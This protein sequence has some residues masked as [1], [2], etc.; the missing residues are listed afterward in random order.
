MLSIMSQN[1][2]RN[3]ENPLEVNNRLSVPGP[4]RAINKVIIPW[5][6]PIS[7]TFTKLFESASDEKWRETIIKRHRATF[8]PILPVP[9][10]GKLS[11]ETELKL[12]IAAL[13]CEWLLARLANPDLK[14]LSLEEAESWFL[15]DTISEVPGLLSNN[16][17]WLPPHCLSDLKGFHINSDFFDL[18]PY[19]LEVFDLID[20]EGKILSRNSRRIRQKLQGVVYTPSDV[21]DYIIRET[22]EHSVSERNY[23]N[24]PICLDPACGTGLFLRSTLDYLVKHNKAMTYLSIL[25][26][27]YGMDI[28]HQAIQSSAFVI[29]A[30]YL[31][32]DPMTPIAPWRVW[33]L[34]RGNLSVI[35]TTLVMR[36]QNGSKD[37]EESILRSQFK[38]NLISTESSIHSIVLQASQSSKIQKT[39]GYL[40]AFSLNDVFPEVSNGF[41]VVVGNPPYSK[42]NND[43]YQAI[44][45]STYETAA[46]KGK[47]GLVYPLFAE[48]L[49]N[50]SNSNRCSGGMILPLS[51]SYSSFSQI[52]RLRKAIQNIPGNWRFVFFDRTPDSLFGDDVKTRNAIVLWE[53][54]EKTN[55]T[56]IST[57]TLLRWNSR[58]RS[59]LFDDIHNVNIRPLTIT[60]LIPKLGTQ[61]ELVTYRKLRDKNE[62]IASMIKEEKISLLTPDLQDPRLVIINSTGY[63]WIPIYREVPT[64]RNKDQKVDIP[65]SIHVYTCNNKDYADFVFACLNSR[66]TYWLWR[67]ESDCF[68]VTRNFVNNLPYQA[69]IFSYSGIEQMRKLSIDLW[70]E[71]KSYPVE[72]VNAGRTRTS[73]YPYGCASTLD[74]IDTLLARA[75]GLSDEF[76]PFVKQ[77]V[78]DNIF[79]GR[80]TETQTNPALRRFKTLN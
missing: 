61:L 24:I 39:A 18:F 17:Q 57:S 11:I 2:T 16:T 51:I 55:E 38:E 28:S 5:I 74:K 72:S 47:T 75:L 42:L 19:I 12:A 7:T 21:S 20:G 59:L 79:A 31:N 53:R 56:S 45:Y 77:F 25:K 49:W 8:D 35:D 9:R 73:Y 58:K 52:K 32:A 37:P 23:E 71:M 50:F 70:R 80:E 27:L 1:N 13:L 65:S 69:S 29:L 44:R 34:I 66:I 30:S 54:N 36:I 63:N 46:T 6:E 67:V 22:L 64:S 14:N 41:D 60:K 15:G 43:D 3:T 10:F 48:M 4:G 33:Q 78:T 26:S 68:H 40:K 62:S 76:V